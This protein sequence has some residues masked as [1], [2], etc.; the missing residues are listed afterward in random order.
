MKALVALPN[1]GQGD[2]DVTIDGVVASEPDYLAT[3]CLVVQRSSH[4]NAVGGIL[5]LDS[6]EIAITAPHSENQIRK[7]KAQNPKPMPSNGGLMLWNSSHSATH[8]HF[9]RTSL[10]TSGWNNTILF[11]ASPGSAARD[12]GE[13]QCSMPESRHSIPDLGCEPV[14]SKRERYFVQH[15]SV[16]HKQ[17]SDYGGQR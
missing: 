16:H 8:A 15:N 12:Q 3:V 11:P 17:D 10:Q 2:S 7:V 9:Q 13:S 4:D 5:T 14:A 1:S 6:L